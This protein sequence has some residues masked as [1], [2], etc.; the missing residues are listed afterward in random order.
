M[1]YQWSCEKNWC[2]PPP[3]PLLPNLVLKERQNRATSTLVTP[4]WTGKVWHHA[5]TEMAVEELTIS[6]ID[7]L[8]RF[9]RR[10]GR[11]MLGKTHGPVI[12]FRIPFRRGSTS[13]D[14]PSRKP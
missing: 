10:A 4:K 5:L 3:W 6:P 14:E 8:F 9:G 11:G 12:V 1:V 7:N 13:K 2:N